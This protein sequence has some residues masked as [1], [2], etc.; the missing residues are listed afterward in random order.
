MLYH[1]DIGNPSMKSMVKSSYNCFGNSNGLSN[2]IGARLEYMFVGKQYFLG[3][4]RKFGF[5]NEEIE[6]ESIINMNN[7]KLFYSHQIIVL[8]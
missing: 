8:H 2:L 7:I 6:N 1:N 4:I 3:F 5:E